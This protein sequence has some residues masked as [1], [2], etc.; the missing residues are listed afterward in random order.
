MGTHSGSVCCCFLVLFVALS[1]SSASSEVFDSVLGSTVSCHKSCEMT[2]SLHTYPREEELYAC[3]RGCRLFSICQFVRDGDDLNKTKSSCESTCHEAYTQS[4]EQYACNLG[5]QNQLPFA[6]QRQEQLEAMMPRIHMLYPLTLVRGLW[7]DMMNQAHS[8]ITS[9]WTFYLQADDGKVVIF[10]SVPEVK[11]FSLFSIENDDNVEQ[12]KSFPELSRPVY[13]EYQRSFI[14]ERD[15]DLTGDDEYGLFGCLSRNPWLPGWILSTTLILSVLVL[16]WICCATVATAVDQYV[17]AEKLSI[18]GDGDIKEKKLIPYPASSLLIVTSK[19]AEEEAGPLPSKVNLDY[20]LLDLMFTE[21]PH[22]PVCPVNFKI[23]VYYEETFASV[24]HDTKDL[25]YNLSESVQMA[26]A[27]DPFQFQEFDEAGSL[28]EANRDS[29]TIS[30]EVEPVKPEKQRKAAGLNPADEDDEFDNDDK[31][32]L[33]SGQQKSVPFWTFE[34]YQRFFDIETHHVKERIIGSMLPW[35][36]KNFIQLY[37]RRNP[38]LYGPIWICTTLVFA[39]AISGNIS[40]FLVHLGKPNYRYTPEF[41]KVTIAATAIFSYAWLVPL[42]LWGFLLWRNNKIMNLVSYSFMEIFCVYGYSLSI[43]IPAVAY[44]FSK[45]EPVQ[46]L[47]S[48]VAAVVTNS[49]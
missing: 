45:P 30:I 21:V 27:N 1:R 40:N 38:D 3:Q 32:E 41:R 16:I 26:S 2:Y 36:G 37:L 42:A 46:H 4:D 11:F 18:Y 44:F 23:K 49:T 28:L 25:K 13:K 7:D 10:Q 8:F 20:F 12:E 47:D 15:R 39:I 29:T 22:F 6:E 19:G 14:Q 35:P 33:L 17:P 5:C 9:T 43:Y 48:P 34:Y 24:F 31:T